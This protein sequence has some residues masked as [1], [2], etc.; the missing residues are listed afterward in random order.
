MKRRTARENA[1]YAAFSATFDGMDIAEIIAQSREE[2]ENEVDE[3]GQQ[4]VCGYFD[5]AAEID[6]L[7]EGHLKGWAMARLPRVS[8]TALRLALSEMLYLPQS[9][10]SVAINE[11]VELAKKFG[12][13]EDYQFVNGLL[14]AIA[15]EKGLGQELPEQPEEN[16]EEAAGEAKGSDE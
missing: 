14:G 8:L 6:A 12:G 9:F 15:R 3:F 2:G 10:T 7:I 4:L 1:F 11:A 16:M 5:H 13:D